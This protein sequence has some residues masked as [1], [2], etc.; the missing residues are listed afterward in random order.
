MNA[1]AQK[2]KAV[3]SVPSNDMTRRF[4]YSGGTPHLAIPPKASGLRRAC[5]PGGELLLFAPGLDKILGPYDKMKQIYPVI[6]RTVPPSEFQYNVRRKF[7]E[8]DD[9]GYRDLDC[10]TQLPYQ[11][12]EGVKD[13]YQDEAYAYF[14]TVHPVITCSFGLEAVY[15]TG[16]EGNVGAEW[17]QPCPTCRLES[18]RSG[19]VE[20]RIKESPLNKTV[21]RK[22]RDS[23]IEANEATLAFA[24]RKI[25]LINADLER[26][27]HGE[28]QGR[29]SRNEIDYINL[30]MAHA[31]LEKKEKEAPQTDVG[32]IVAATVAAFKA[33]QEEK[34]VD[35]N[36][37]EYLKW[38]DEQEKAEKPK[39]KDK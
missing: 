25:D 31:T 12:G 15:R 11:V 8:T 9:M 28:P 14:S 33:Q 19:D 38:K 3:Q 26:R 1:I 24:K 30:R 16:A 7:F 22:L 27:A 36:Y 29:T 34:P 13:G 35:P 10:L 18:L 4:G 23:L 21:L 37:V 32:A 39:T 6:T 20:K 5:V 2:F 17:Y